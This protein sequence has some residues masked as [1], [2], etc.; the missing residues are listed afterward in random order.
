MMIRGKA[1]RRANEKIA[2]SGRIQV[3][4]DWWIRYRDEEPVKEEFA[5]VHA[6]HWVSVVAG[7]LERNAGN[8]KTPNS[9]TGVAGM[10]GAMHIDPGHMSRQKK[11]GHP[12]LSGHFFLALAA[13]L[14]VP[15]ESLFPGKA[16]WI[17]EATIRLCRASV[18]HEE[19]RL[20]AAYCLA[21][22]CRPESGGMLL[23]VHAVRTVMRDQAIEEAACVAAILKVDGQ[24]SNILRDVLHKR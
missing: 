2:T 19:S 21:A 20:F 5:K 17:A 12:G 15:L 16:T 13:I 9:W 6:A 7:V 8:G 1:A 14:D 18:S 3:P 23:N 22:V 24:L 4:P 10:A 11:G